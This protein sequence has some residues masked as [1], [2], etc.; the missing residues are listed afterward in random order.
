MVTGDTFDQMVL[1]GRGPIAVEFMSYSCE[2]CRAMEPVIDQVAEMV[3]S[4][5]TIFKV[6]IATDPE[7]GDRCGVRATPTLV[8][9]LDGKKVG[10][11]EGPS[12]SVAS[13]LTAVSQPFRVIK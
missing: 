4:K 6:N 10:Q 2:H 8:M 9:F 11:A 7:L 12:P 13:V 5:G 1:E 3:K